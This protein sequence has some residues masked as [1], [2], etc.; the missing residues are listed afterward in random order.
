MASGNRDNPPPSPRVTLG[1]VTFPCVVVAELPLG[2]E[3]GGGK[4]LGWTS[5]LTSAGRITL[6]DGKT[7]L[8]INTLAR[9]IR[10]TLV[11]ARVKKSHKSLNLYQRRSVTE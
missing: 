9:L 1:E 8:H 7:F 11:V 5:C 10:K 4:Q 2:G 6:A 3:G